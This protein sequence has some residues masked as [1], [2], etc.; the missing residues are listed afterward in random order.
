LGPDGDKMSK[1]KGNVVNPDD[2][3][4]L[5]GADT[6]RMYMQ[7]LGPHGQ[8]VAWNDKGI[9]GLRRFIERVWNLHEKVTVM[10]KVDMPRD[11]EVLLHQTI[12]KVGDDIMSTGFNTA[13]SSLMILLN[14]IEKE[15]DIPYD[16]STIC[17]SHN[18][19]NVESF[20]Q[21]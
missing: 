12:K 13:I 15:P 14:R 1:S 20:R 19:R 3:V 11:L 5:Y 10:V 16:F 8:Q 2:I 7:F 6:T 18:R 9:I 17:S 21:Y 4:E